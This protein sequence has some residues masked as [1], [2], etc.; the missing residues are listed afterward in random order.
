MRKILMFALVLAA[1][2][3]AQQHPNLAKGF[4][5]T[6][7]Y[8][9]HGLDSV[10]TFNGNLNVRIPLGQAYSVAPGLS[11]Q[12][13]LTWNSNSWL[14]REEPSQ[15]E[16]CCI[17]AYP[18]DKSNA[19]FG[20]NFS[21]GSFSR[22]PNAVS[23]DG[24][25]SYVSPDGAIHSFYRHLNPADDALAGDSLVGY[26]RDGSYLRGRCI[27]SLN[28]NDAGDRCIVEFPNG[29]MHRFKP[30]SDGEGPWML[31]TMANQF[32][33]LDPISNYYTLNYVTVEYSSDAQ[34]PQI[35]TITDSRGREHKVYFR[36]ATE[37][38]DGE[39]LI[40]DHFE[41]ASFEKNKA[42][43][44]LG[45]L[46]NYETLRPYWHDPMSRTNIPETAKLWLLST[47]HGKD[48]GTET[49]A[50]EDISYAFAYWNGSSGSHPGYLTQMTLP[51]GG[52]IVWNLTEYSLPNDGPD[53]GFQQSTGVKTRK[54]Y[55]RGKDPNCGTD[56][57]CMD[58]ILMVGMV[59]GGGGRLKAVNLPAWRKI[60]INM[61][62]I[63]A[64]HTVGGAQTSARATKFIGMSERQIERAIREAYRNGRTVSTQGDT[65]RVLGQSNG[66]TIEMWV[67][68]ATRIIESA[69]PV[70]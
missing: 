52:M 20:W 17:V 8:D 19:G 40:V 7:V 29:T 42:V 6:G 68:K 67:N 4:S 2:V 5:G 31:E 21:L 66:L 41:L 32:S 26:T 45:Y 58:L 14:S 11:Y 70:F 33:V 62:H 43:Y 65:V 60:T 10:N 56:A 13:A 24:T 50:S 61:S 49:T 53:Y 55:G 69:Y 22:A 37:H 47:V 44:T 9:V 35:W 39:R 59:H 1:P 63:V 46:E 38:D 34:W 51:T 27:E 30:P 48:A 16:D 54:A 12:F 64:R 3:W 25:W 57:E 28:G 15:Y 18:D 36:M 23:G